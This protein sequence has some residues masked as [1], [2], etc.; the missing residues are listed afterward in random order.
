MAKP[1]TNDDK[2]VM[3][4]VQGVVSPPMHRGQH[5]FDKNGKPFMLPGTGGIT[6]NIQA[7]DPAFGW[8]ADH[9]E[10]SVS[11]IANF[12][13]RFEGQNNGFNFYSCTGNT[14]TIVSGDA[15]GDKGVVLGHHGGAEH[16]IIEFSR[17]IK[18]KML[19]DDK[20]LIK[21]FGQGLK[22]VDYPE[23][24]VCNLDPRILDKWDIEDTG[25]GIK[26]PV[27]AVVPG[28]L[29]GSGVGSTSMGR[30]DY[31]IM[32]ADEKYIAELGLDKLRF[33]D[34]VAI[35][36]HDN[37]YGRS[38]RRGAISIGIVMHGNCQYAGHGPGVTTLISAVEP[39]LIEYEVTDKANIAKILSLGKFAKPEKDK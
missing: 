33:G 16:V 30:G 28:Q 12:E 18:D 17:E 8:E 21:G 10:P 23:I 20:I 15:K 5:S 26:V 35:T 24:A 7:G 19:M 9:I 13:K 32:T 27:A 4:S 25:H 1:K 31:D 6:Y 38:Y 11:A 14:A 2:L 37:R 29:M 36:D 34:F 22:F 39:G 3:I